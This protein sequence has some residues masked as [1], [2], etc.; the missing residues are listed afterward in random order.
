MRRQNYSARAFSQRRCC[1]TKVFEEQN[2]CRARH[3]KPVASRRELKAPETCIDPN[4][5]LFRKLSY[6]IHCIQPRIYDPK[7]PKL[8]QKLGADLRSYR[9]RL[10]WLSQKT[11]GRPRG[12]AFKTRRTKKSR[13]FRTGTTQSS[14]QIGFCPGTLQRL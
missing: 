12:R 11:P 8:A 6:I 14:H 13:L 3:S 5:I 9:Y 2:R 4:H 10:G 1:C 7:E